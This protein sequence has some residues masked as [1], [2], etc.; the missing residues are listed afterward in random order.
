MLTYLEFMFGLVRFL[1]VEK[2]NTLWSDG[3][4]GK[5]SFCVSDHY[6]VF[7]ATVNQ[8]EFIAIMTGDI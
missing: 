2:F 4:L 1:Y 7:F 8:E 6:I 5:E 3:S